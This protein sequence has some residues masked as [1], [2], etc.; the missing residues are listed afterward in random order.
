LQ[1]KIK[2]L[3]H[4]CFLITSEA[5]T[6][7]ITDP[8]STGGGIN[9]PEIRESA[10][11]VLSSH[12]HGDHSNTRAIKGN[13]QIIK[14]VGVKE[15]K[16]IEFKGL[17]SYHDDAKGTKRGNN[18][19]FVFEVDGMKICHLGDLGHELNTMQLNELGK[20]DI[21]F[22]PV[23]GFYTFDIQVAKNVYNNIAPKVAIPMHYKTPKLDTSAFGAIVGPDDFLK[24]KTNVDRR[25]SNEIEFKAGQLPVSTEIVVLMPP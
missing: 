3:G 14:S 11:I 17:A 21:L 10:D 5:G 1:L 7:I 22:I 6:R 8:F 20:V 15:A 4:A 2:W 13:P 12:D 24:G 19:I 25:D 23:G 18:T 16:G 9:Y